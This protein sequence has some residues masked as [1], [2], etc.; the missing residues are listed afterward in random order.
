MV[1][2]GPPAGGWPAAVE[3]RRPAGKK[4]SGAQARRA[5]RRAAMRAQLEAGAIEGAMEGGGSAAAT[6]TEG[7][8]QGSKTQ[9]GAAAAQEQSR[10][11][12]PGGA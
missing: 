10:V 5:A 4:L 12:D 1:D 2:A 6:G 9:D 11:F 3:A 7:V 8:V